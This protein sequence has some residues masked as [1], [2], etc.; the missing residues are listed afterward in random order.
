MLT[1][2]KWS[3]L[4]IGLSS[5]QKCLLMPGVLKYMTKPHCFVLLGRMTAVSA[6]NVTTAGEQTT[7]QAVFSTT[8]NQ[9]DPGVTEL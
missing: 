1:L 7:S 3:C 5:D 4:M 8:S 2:K 9:S 6:C